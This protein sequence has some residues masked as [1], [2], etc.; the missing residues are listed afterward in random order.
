MSQIRDRMLLTGAAHA[1]F[2]SDPSPP[3]DARCPSGSR[4]VPAYKLA[5]PL[6]WLVRCDEIEEALPLLEDT[7]SASDELWMCWLAFLNHALDRGG[8]RVS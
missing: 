6:G 1:T 3:L 5:E 7:C 4:G 2:P 8:F